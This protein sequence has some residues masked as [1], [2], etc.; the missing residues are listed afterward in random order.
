VLAVEQEF[1]KKRRPIYRER[2][3]ALSRIPAFWKKV[4][5]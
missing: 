2:S 1:N 3:Y 4:R 5:A